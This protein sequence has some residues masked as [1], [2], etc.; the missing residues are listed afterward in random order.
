[1]RLRNKVAAITG[2]ASG[3]GLAC[4][5][6][7]EAE[8]ARV[9]GA[10]VAGEPRC[11]VA[12]FSDMQEFAK[13]AGDAQVLVHAAGIAIPG[14][15]LETSDEDFERMWRVN[16]LGAVHMV[17]AF[18]PQL[19]EGASVIF[20]SSINALVGAPGL[21]GYA[22]SKGALMTL[23]HSLALELASRGIRVN[24]ICPASIDTPMLRASFDRQPDPATARARN[25]LRHPLGRLGVPED[26]ANLALFLASDESSW[27]TGSVHMID[28]GALINRS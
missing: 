14:R 8:G 2:A 1:M 28:G 5:E 16:F 3:I 6:R 12:S 7:F 17:R 11:D 26:V 22:A 21:S 25:I 10:D 15:T 23:G 20:V 13:R 4:V 19:R 24:T 18:E 9:F 27:I